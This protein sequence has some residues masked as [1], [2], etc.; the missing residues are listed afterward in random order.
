MSPQI[1]I[2]EARRHVRP[3]ID[4]DDFGYTASGDISIAPRDDIELPRPLRARPGIT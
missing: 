1:I 3:N 2:K 4:A